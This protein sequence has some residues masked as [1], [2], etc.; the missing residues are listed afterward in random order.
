[1]RSLDKSGAA[2]ADTP[3]VSVYDVTSDSITSASFGINREVYAILNNNGAEAVAKLDL[4][5]STVG[6]VPFMSQY[7][8]PDLT[9]VNGNA[10]D[11]MPIS[12]D[13]RCKY[14]TVKFRCGWYSYELEA[15][16]EIQNALNAIKL[17]V[18][19]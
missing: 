12:G 17:D 2:F 3:S 14:T 13:K 1:M 8:L 4:I 6:G 5:S 10:Y 15:T 18:V 16:E 9:S 11:Y 19:A 7:N